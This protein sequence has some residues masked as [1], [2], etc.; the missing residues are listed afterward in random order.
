MVV[1]HVRVAEEGVGDGEE[2]D[3][4]ALRQIGGDGGGG[5]EIPEIGKFR[6]R[7]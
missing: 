1:Y 5:K 2:G 7:R 6:V 3:G 4:G